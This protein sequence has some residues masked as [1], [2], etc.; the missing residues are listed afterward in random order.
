MPAPDI[1]ATHAAK[2]PDK[3]AL[4]DDPPPNPLLCTH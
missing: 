4:I 1:L 2:I 3:L